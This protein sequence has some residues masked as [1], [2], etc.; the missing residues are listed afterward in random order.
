MSEHIK[1]YAH[2][3]QL[4]IDT[5]S[6]LEQRKSLLQSINDTQLK[7][8]EEIVYNLLHNHKINFTRKEKEVIEKYNT[9]LKRITN[10]RVSNLIKRRLI[11]DRS[12]AL[13][14]IFIAIG[15]SLNPILKS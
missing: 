1:T 9:L 7:V 10:P 8:I 5:N 11:Y 3:I 2:F 15:E 14:K 12:T 13:A 4:L 6:S